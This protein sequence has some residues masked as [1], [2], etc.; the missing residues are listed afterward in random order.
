VLMKHLT[1]KMVIPN[2]MRYW[3][4]PKEYGHEI[5]ILDDK[6]EVFTI[7]LR[8]TKGSDEIFTKDQN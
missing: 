4:E 6:E 7:E 5:R 1:N 2:A 3:I 8:G